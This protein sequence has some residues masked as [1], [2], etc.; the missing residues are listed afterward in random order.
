[1][2]RYFDICQEIGTSFATLFKLVG[3]NSLGLNV[4]KEPIGLAHH[5]SQTAASACRPH[6]RASCSLQAQNTSH[7]PPRTELDATLALPRSAQ[8]SRFRESCRCRMETVPAWYQR[9]S[10]TCGLRPSGLFHRGACQ[11]EIADDIRGRVYMRDVGLVE[12]VHSQPA[13]GITR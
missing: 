12:L 4:F 8:P 1:M 10:G 7:V 13:A 6:R 2:R 11:C 5:F 3:C 9:G